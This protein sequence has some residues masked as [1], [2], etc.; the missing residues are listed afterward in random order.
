MGKPV[1]EWPGLDK[2][3]AEHSVGFP[4]AQEANDVGVYVCTEQGHG[5]TGSEGS[6]GDV[7]SGEAH[8][9]ADAGRG[10]AEGGRDVL[11]QDTV[12]GVGVV[13]FCQWDVQGRVVLAMM[14][15]A[16]ERGLDGAAEVVSR[17]TLAQGFAA[18][19]IF[20]HPEGICDIVGCEEVVLGERLPWEDLVVA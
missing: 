4:A 12:Q 16:A 3:V 11:G 17:C 18:D 15:E 13:V 8:C 2:E 10:H 20:L 5:A 7:L 14:E 6:G 19:A 9:M 1:D